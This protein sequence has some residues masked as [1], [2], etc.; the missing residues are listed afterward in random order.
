MYPS[1]NSR[2]LLLDMDTEM[3]DLKMAGIVIACCLVLLLILLA[4]GTP[5]ART[6]VTPPFKPKRQRTGTT[7]GNS[8]MITPGVQPTSPEEGEEPAP[9]AI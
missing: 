3:S 8:P 4:I 9:I 2:Q 1:R 5:S 7:P 6:R